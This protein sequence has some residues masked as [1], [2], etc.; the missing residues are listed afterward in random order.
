VV[1]LG[2]VG[3][4]PR[5]QYHAL[6]LADAGAEVDLIGLAGS[7]PFAGVREHPNI[8][9]NRLRDGGRPGDAGPFV[10]PALLRAVRQAVALSTALAGRRHDV[11]LAQSPPALPTVAVALLAARLRGARLVIDW[12]NLGHAVLALRLGDAH[13]AVGVARRAEAAFGRRADAHLCVSRA[14]QRALAERWG[15]EAALLYDRPARQFGPLAPERR[16]AVVQRLCH[17]LGCDSTGRPAVVI[18]P[19]SW[20][21]DED[22]PL[23]IE[24]L[25]HCEA[26][27]QAVDR[28]APLLVLL[29]GTGP[30]R[31]DYERRLA[32]LPRA[33]VHAHALWLSPDEYPAMLASADLGLS[34]HRSAS[35]L[36]LPIKIADMFGAGVPVCALDYGACLREVVRPGEN[37]L[38]FSSAADLAEQLCTLACRAP[39]D[40]ASLARLR[41]G[42]AAAAA[43]RWDDAW[44]RDAAA[45]VL[46]DAVAHERA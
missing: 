21:A 12:H 31:A 32:R 23:L 33:R 16:E 24:A 14:M 3:R 15:I 34:L 40:T 4:S 38:L 45:V 10:V 26:R 13:P 22:F 9:L 7:A 41:A 46:G 25:A 39:A 44:R 11:I 27:L 35:G 1:V 36:D 2:D 5:M 28:A 18:S 6:A 17:R 42:A 20:T 19:T 37:A 30:L 29:T 8:H 43:E